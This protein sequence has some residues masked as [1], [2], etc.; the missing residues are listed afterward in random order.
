[1]LSAP[2]PPRVLRRSRCLVSR[3]CWVFST[4]S[5]L[6][7]RCSAPSNVHLLGETDPGAPGLGSERGA[8]LGGSQLAQPG[9]GACARF[10]VVQVPSAAS[11]RRADTI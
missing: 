5:G 11:L 4:A 9:R 1:M 8:S 3:S 6:A 10:S 7:G 2:G